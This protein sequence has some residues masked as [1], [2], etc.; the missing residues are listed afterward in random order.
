MAIAGGRNGTVLPAGRVQ[1]VA[2]YAD[3]R[4]QTMAPIS[5]NGPVQSMVEAPDGRVWLGT[6]GS[7]LLA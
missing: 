7:G 5:A 3:G 6:E 1:G 2:R 4:F